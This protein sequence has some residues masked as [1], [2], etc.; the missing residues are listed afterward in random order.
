MTQFR[1]EIALKHD[2][3]INTN[4]FNILNSGPKQWYSEWVKKVKTPFNRTESWQREFGNLPQQNLPEWN[5]IFTIPCKATRETKIQSFAFK[6]LYRL[7]PCNRHLHKLWIRES[8]V[9]SFCNEVD[10]IIHFFCGCCTVRA[11]WLDLTS[12]WGNYLDIQL[13]HRSIPEL[14]L[15]VLQGL[16]LSTGSLYKQNFTFR[17]G[18]CFVKPTYH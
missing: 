5:K 4:R 6:V 18:N 3:V 16:E 11:F 9:C 12:W 13:D 10:T 15:G 8:H 17:N 7:T 14:L 2:F 1:Q